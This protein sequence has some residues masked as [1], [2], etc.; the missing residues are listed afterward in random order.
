MKYSDEK[1]SELSNEK[2]YINYR[3]IYKFIINIYYNIIYNV[4]TVSISTEQIQNVNMNECSAQNVR[5]NRNDWQIKKEFA[6]EVAVNEFGKYWKIL[7]YLV[8]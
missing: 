6:E 7:I 2:E 4:Y 8:I 5:M 1:R 3:L